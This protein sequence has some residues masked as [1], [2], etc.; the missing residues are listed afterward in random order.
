MV[1]LE[2]IKEGCC[3]REWRGFWV[4]N[5]GFWGNS[6]KLK[7]KRMKEKIENGEN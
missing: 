3:S 1:D 4:G 5:C 2:G 6:G 7:W